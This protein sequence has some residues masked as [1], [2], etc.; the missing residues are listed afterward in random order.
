MTGR[1]V[2]L[3]GVKLVNPVGGKLATYDQIE[4]DG[5]LL[6]LEPAHP[7]STATGGVPAANEPFVNIIPTNLPGATSSFK[8]QG[9]FASGPSIYGEIE[10][11]GK[12]GIH[13]IVSQANLLGSGRG[14]RIQLPLALDEYFV[15]N[16]GHHYYLSIWDRVTRDIATPGA[17]SCDYAI[18]SSTSG[19]IAWGYNGSWDA[20]ASPIGERPLP[21]T[22]GPRFSS[23]GVDGSATTS[24]YMGDC[25]WPTWGTPS[26]TLNSVTT[27]MRDGRWASF[28]FYRAYFEDLTVS[29]RTYAEVDA[30]DYQLFIREVLT[31]GGRYYGDTFTDPATIP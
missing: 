13:G 6:L 20:G 24:A 16:P 15:A 1:K 25:G 11:T 29:G 12:G 23:F 31:P 2:V 5:S 14:A 19:G 7:L 9:E 4:S 3:Q 30:L 22:V 18:S 10:R 8:V 27:G 26:V 21:D 17:T 28:I